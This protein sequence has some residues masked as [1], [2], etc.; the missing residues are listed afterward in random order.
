[1]NKFIAYSILAVVREG[2][3]TFLGIAQGGIITTITPHP[4]E[5]T[6]MLTIANFF[7]GLFG[8]K[9]PEQ[10]MTI[11]IDLIGNNVIKPKKGPVSGLYLKLFV[12]WGHYQ[13]CGGL[14]SLVQLHH[15]GTGRSV[16]KHRALF[17]A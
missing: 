10:I 5:R 4:V 17:R 15:E 7:S 1:M 13:Y 11:L 16:H 6:R 3:G 9:L 8:E 14:V 2:I 12:G